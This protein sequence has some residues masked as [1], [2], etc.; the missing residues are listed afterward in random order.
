MARRHEAGDRVA[1]PAAERHCQ[2]HRDRRQAS[3]MSKWRVRRYGKQPI[4][5]Q[6]AIR[7][8]SVS[9]EGRAVEPKSHHGARSRWPRSPSRRREALL[10]SQRPAASVVGVE[11]AGAY[12]RKAACRRSESDSS[13][14]SLDGRKSRENHRAIAARQTAKALFISTAQRCGP[15]TWTATAAVT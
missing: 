8:R 14:L 4:G 1:L 6:K 12:V 9:M 5:G 3:C 7:P 13:T 2:A 11:V 15:V 10:G